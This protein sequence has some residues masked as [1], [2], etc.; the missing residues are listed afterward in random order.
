MWDAQNQAICC[1]EPAI[2]GWETKNGRTK[3]TCGGFVRATKL[4]RK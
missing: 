4:I 2:F 3:E 1:I